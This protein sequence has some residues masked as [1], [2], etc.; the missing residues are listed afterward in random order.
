MVETEAPLYDAEEAESIILS[1]LKPG[2]VA[3]IPIEKI[4]VEQ[5]FNARDFSTPDNKDHVARLAKLIVANGIENPLRVRIDGK[6]IVL[7]DGESR[8]R[9][10]LKIRDEGKHSIS[11][12]VPCLL[13]VEGTDEKD[14]ISSLVVKNSGKSLTILETVDVVK[15][16]GNLGVNKKDI[17]RMLGFSPAHMTN[18]GIL[19][20]VA[21]EIKTFIRQGKISATTVI[22]LAREL[23]PEDLKATVVK[24]IKRAEQ[25]ARESGGKVSS[26]ATKA[27]TGEGPVYNKTVFNGLINCLQKV[28]ASLTPAADYR[29]QRSW[30]R[31]ALENANAPVEVVEE[32]EE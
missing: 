22:D 2:I 6:Y 9:A 3:H 29:K 13:D 31:N 24:A 26:K 23:T 10:V 25:D 19:D 15:R 20:K 12:T 32:E 30:I 16:L 1:A 14:R 27:D 5:G 11:G 7:T 4:N 18:L 17:Q 8:F 28:F 21:D